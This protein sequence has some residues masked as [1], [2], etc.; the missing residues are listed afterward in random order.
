MSTTA[1]ASA[2]SRAQQDEAFFAQIAEHSKTDPLIGAKLGS[3]EVSQ[4]LVAALKT[5]QGLQIES[6]IA[7][8][9]ALAGYACQAS[10]RAQAVAQ[11][12]PETALMDAVQATDGKTYYLGEALNRALV[13]STY[14]VWGV[15][16]AGAQE[17]GCAALPDITEIFS[18]ACSAIGGDAFGQYRAGAHKP[19]APP[20][21]YVNQLWT[22]IFNIVVRFCPDP[23]HWPVLLAVALRDAIIWGKS[24][25][26]PCVSLQLGMD[27]AVQ[28]SMVELEGK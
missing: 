4:R 11:G 6:L 1:D 27:A 23:Q 7:V 26:D 17:A 28:M 12:L 20:L 3:K 2:Q 14:S 5:N 25:L 18:F 9:G 21:D 8:L 16:A 10:V 19:G 15:A 24:V 22:P 13:Q